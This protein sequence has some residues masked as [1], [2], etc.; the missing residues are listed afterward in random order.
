MSIDAPRPKSLDELIAMLERSYAVMADVDSVVMPKWGLGLLIE[1]LHR[2][3]G[4]A[5]HGQ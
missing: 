4:E 1:D 3:A 2:F 5:Q